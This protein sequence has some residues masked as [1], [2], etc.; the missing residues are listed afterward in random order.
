MDWA[1]K[2]YKHQIKAV[3]LF[4]LNA[5]NWINDIC[6]SDTVAFTTALQ[7]EMT[8]GDGSK[9]EGEQQMDTGGDQME[10]GGRE[11]EEAQKKDNEQVD[12]DDDDTMNVE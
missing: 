3:N 1:S 11:K 7:N 5:G 6:I 8:G 4:F 10:T 9:P 12:D 2:L